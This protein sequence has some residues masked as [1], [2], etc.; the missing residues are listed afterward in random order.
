[1]MLSRWLSVCLLPNFT[2]KDDP[3]SLNQVCC[4]QD[5]CCAMFM[6]CAGLWMANERWFEGVSF[7][8][9]EVRGIYQWGT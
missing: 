6:F 8:F 2:D 5:S 9:G 7:A 3:A 1:M 4:K